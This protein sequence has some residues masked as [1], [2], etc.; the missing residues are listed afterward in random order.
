MSDIEFT[1]INGGGLD[2]LDPAQVRTALEQAM[3]K[4]AT[5]GA[6]Q[7]KVNAPVDEGRLRAS[8]T[9]D[10]RDEGSAIVGVIGSNV[11]YAPYMEHGTG[12]LADE[13]GSGRHNPPPSALAGWA[14][15]HGLNPYAVARA[16]AKR[17]GLKPRRFFRDAIESSGFASTV[18]RYVVE[19]VNKVLGI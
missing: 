3:F 6:N 17:G 2:K 15:R 10:V 9:A 4:A 13:G 8:I 16:I 14:S 7:A 5:Q 12:L 1:L 11:E 19:A 18:E